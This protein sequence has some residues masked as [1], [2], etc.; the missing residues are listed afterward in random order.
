MALL[1]NC[2]KVSKS[3]GSQILF[4][5]FSLAIHQ[6]DCLGI[7]GPNGT[8]K[9]TLLKLMA[10]SEPCDGGKIDRRKGVRVAQVAQEEAFE[11]DWTA[12]CILL[13]AQDGLSLPDYEKEARAEIHLSR[14]GIEESSALAGSLSGGFQKRLAIAAAL[15]V[16]PDLLLLDEP[17][18]H[19][20]LVGIRWLEGLLAGPAFAVV[21]VS[22]DRYF[23]ES[24]SNRIIELDRRYP[25][26]VLAVQGG[27]SRFLLAKEAFLLAQRRR[28]QALAIQVRRER[29]WLSH[30][31]KARGG[32]AKSRQRSAY[33]AIEE[34]ESVRR[35]GRRSAT[36]IEFASAGS[37]SKVLLK[38]EQI[39]KSVAGRQLFSSL[40]LILSPKMRLGLVG[41]NGSGKTTLLKVLAGEIEADEGEIFRRDGLKVAWFDQ[42]RKELD[43]TLTLRQALAPSGGQAVVFR[44]QPIDIRAWAGRFLFREEQLDLVLGRLSGGERARLL[45][46]RLMLQPAD[47]LL[48]D[49]PTNDLDIPTLEVLQESLDSFPGAIL[50]VTHDRYLL[51]RLCGQVLGLDGRGA[52]LVVAD[53]RQWE[54]HLQEMAP[55]PRRPERTQQPE[56]KPP[57]RPHKLSY[58]DQREWDGMEGKILEAETGLEACRQAMQD[59]EV[60]SDPEQLQVRL[61]ALQ[62]A[63]QKVEQLYQRWAELEAKLQA[64]E[65]VSR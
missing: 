31:P 56:R 23:L 58:R 32:K 22:H 42:H 5:D 39:G 43:P 14:A 54:R 27:Y 52:S 62:S 10:G 53:W 41:S 51:D 3:F 25:E 50:L 40:D 2:R 60:A 28:E 33:E 48:L 57:R 16:E 64:A 24:V 59:P 30:A 17:T 19:L 1:L 29:E 55:E 35:R 65:Q 4:E 13:Q 6:G 9:S 38:A 61:A 15:V 21:A 37:R 12:R 34:L 44:G 49:E 36:A 11:P 8:G 20:D 26:G 18:N 7:I 47:V 46:A 45:I 63:Q